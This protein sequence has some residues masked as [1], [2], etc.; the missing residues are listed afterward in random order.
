ML[1]GLAAV[2]AGR[3]DLVDAAVLH[4]SFPPMVECVECEGLGRMECYECGHEDECVVCE[5]VGERLA[6]V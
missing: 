5:G 3:P 4:E 6:E 1:A 2:Q